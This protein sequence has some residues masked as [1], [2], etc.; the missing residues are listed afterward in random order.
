[1]HPQPSAANYLSPLHERARRQLDTYWRVRVTKTIESLE[2][3]ARRMLQLELQLAAFADEYYSAVGPWAEYLAA[4]EAQFETPIAEHKEDL[5]TLPLALAQRELKA[6]REDELKARYRTLAKEIHP[7]RLDGDGVGIMAE[8]MQL[9]NDAYARGD[10]A[11]L[12]K[13]EAE[14]LMGHLCN[15]WSAAEG[16]LRDIERAVE[17]YASGYRALLNSPLNHLMLR[18]MSATQSGWDWIGAVIQRLQRAIATRE[19]MLRG[20][21]E[22]AVA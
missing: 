17:T 15:D 1:M 11:L 13:C 22:I 4:L 2:R 12:L 8:K 7:D 18:A 9:V 19:E 21:V 6:A 14:I 20:G 3:E 10:L 16:H 5:E